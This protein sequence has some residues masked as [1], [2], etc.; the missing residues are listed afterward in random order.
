MVLLVTWHW[1]RWLL[2]PPMPNFQPKNVNWILLFRPAQDIIKLL[3]PTKA[4]WKTES[5]AGPSSNVE[6][7]VT[8]KF[9]WGP[10]VEG[11]GGN[12]GSKFP[13]KRIVPNA[14]PG[15]RQT[16]F[17]VAHGNSPIAITSSVEGVKVSYKNQCQW[18]LVNQLKREYKLTGRTTCTT[19]SEPGE[20]EV[21]LAGEPILIPCAKHVVVKAAS[22]A[23]TVN[24]M[25]V[26]AI[27]ESLELELVGSLLVKTFRGRI[28]S[29]YY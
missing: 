17:V 12:W 22:N 9:C 4:A 26:V 1:G 19:I 13:L 29:P 5:S 6:G 23:A 20:T 14:S 11:G 21:S 15:G 16:E 24:F 25:V 8:V 18:S 7:I 10:P 27:G 3:T 28:A 2:S